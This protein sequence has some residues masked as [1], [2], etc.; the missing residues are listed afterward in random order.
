MEKRL[1]LAAAALAL[2][3]IGL[4][5]VLAMVANTFSVAGEF[6]LS[7][8]EALMASGKQLTLLMGHS[9]L[10]SLSV[11][12][13]AMIVGVPL[14]VVL[15]KT[16]LPLRGALTMLLTL[17]LLIPPYVIA[18]A[19]FAVLGSAGWIGHF[20]SPATSE[21][22]SS[23]FF[24][25]YGCIGVLSTA[26]LPVAMLLTI[27]YLGTVNPRL[28][29]AGLLMSRWP[30]VLWRITLPLIA[31]AILFAAVLVFLLTL[32][33]VGVPTFVR[34]PVYPVEILTQ[35]AAFY[36]F[37]AATVAAI[38]LLAITTVIS[39]KTALIASGKPFR[40]STTAMRTS[41]TPRFLSSFITRSQNLAPSE[42]SIHRPRM[43]FAPSGSWM[44]SRVTSSPG[45]PARR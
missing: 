20:L 45:S 15:G 24:G 16:D 25:L 12:L 7:A 27:A 35:F 31:P 34:Y 40:P 10:L 38:P 26:F 41:P 2:V 36:D 14:G 9:I 1:T 17:P 39:G 13:L 5:P 43:S 28:E 23:T 32:G 6:S 18:V 3:A 42:V 37:S 11:T 22:L 29:Q 8:Y 30:H 33:E 19:W 21:F 44:T 4:L